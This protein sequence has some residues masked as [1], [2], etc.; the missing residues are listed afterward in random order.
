MT[1]PLYT[2]YTEVSDPERLA[3]NPRVSIMMVTYLHEDY[4]AAAIEGIAAQQTDFEFELIVAEDRSPDGTLDVALAMQKKYPHFVRVIY[5]PQN[6]GAG[7]NTLLAMSLCRGEYFGLCEG[8]DLWIDEGKLARQVAVLDARP[9][10]DLSFTGGYRLYA[11]GARV[12]EWDWGP[13]PR[14]VPARE[15]LGTFGWPAPTASLVL[16]FSAIRRLPNWF[17]QTKWGDLVLIIAGSV[18]GGAHYDPARTICYRVAHP[19]SFTVQLQ[20]AAAAERIAYFEDAIEKLADTCGF[21]GLPRRDVLH[22]I[23]DYRLSLAKLQLAEGMRMRA[24]RT[25]ASVSPLFVAKGFA[26]RLRKLVTP[27]GIA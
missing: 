26:R 27:S 4:L 23:N 5:S 11:D 12:P 2:D 22:R 7:R 14:V 24:I 20:Q 8:D 17:G 6:K 25:L 16:R 1:D 13:E 3:A 9:E 18:R 10:V 19:S 21:Y 15:L